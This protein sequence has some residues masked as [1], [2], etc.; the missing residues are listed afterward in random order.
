MNPIEHPAFP[1]LAFCSAILVLKM[2][3]VGHATGA[4]RFRKRAFAAPEDFDAFK[5]EG[6]QKEDPLVERFLRAHHNDLESTL[7]FL[8][9]ALVYLSIDPSPGLAQGLFV[10]FTACRCL[11]SIFYLASLQ[12]WRSLSFLAGEVSVVVMAV[13]LGWWGLSNWA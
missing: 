13:Q 8:A 1:A 10:W 5:V 12:P 9:I 4:V 7:P 11:F 2:I 3:I 6:K